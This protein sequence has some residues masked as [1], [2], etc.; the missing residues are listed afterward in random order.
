[1]ADEGGTRGEKWAAEVHGEG[2]EAGPMQGGGAA[3]A[4]SELRVKGGQFCF[5]PNRPSGSRPQ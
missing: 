2:R 5:V 3:P 4:T 1:M